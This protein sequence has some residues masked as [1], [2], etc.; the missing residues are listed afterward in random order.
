[1]DKPLVRLSL[2]LSAIVVIGLIVTFGF[3]FNLDDCDAEGNCRWNFFNV[4]LMVTFVL[5]GFVTFFG[6]LALPGGKNPDGTFREQRVRF[7]ITASL[8]ICYLVLLTTSVFWRDDQFNVTMVDT[9]T[10]LMM[11]VLPFYFGSS[12]AV[13]WATKNKKIDSMPETEGNPQ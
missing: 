12:A 11:I 2:L 6:I 13:E 1:M 3:L 8:L 9:L 10:N 5:A 7:T 4:G